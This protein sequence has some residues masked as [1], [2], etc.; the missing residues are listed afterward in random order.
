MSHAPLKILVVDDDPQGLEVSRKILEAE[1][2][3]V[4]AAADGLEALERVRQPGATWDA[5]LTDVRMPRMDGLEF[6]KAVALVSPSTPVVLMTAFGRLDEAV[7][8]MKLGA[9][10]FLAKPFKRKQLLDAVEAATRRA[11]RQ[12]SEGGSSRL[13]RMEHLLR[14]VDQVA[15]TSATLLVQ[16]ESGVGKERLA[17]EIHQRSSRKM[18][19]FIAINCAAIP[20][21]LLESELFGH[22]KGAFT[23]AQNAKPGLFEAASGGTL[24]L[25]EI[26]DM[27]YPLQAK[28][29]RVLQEGEVRR[30]GAIQN[31]KVDVRVIASTHQNLRQRVEQGL[32]R[33]DLFYRLEV[34]SLHVPPL[35]ERREDILAL[36]HSFLEEARIRH[37]KAGVIRFEPAAL[38]ALARHDWPGNIRELSNAIE[39]AVVLCESASIG[40]EDLPATVTVGKEL[41]GQDTGVISTEGSQMIT[42]P[43]GTSLKEVEELL[44]RRT[45]EST[46]GDKELAAQLLGIAARTIYRKLERRE[47][48]DA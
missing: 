45:L 8:A 48:A 35:R 26:G 10:D 42:V 20:E 41:Q 23:G 33:Q 37:S 18:G 22:E 29:L 28:L 43:L 11:R 25:D 5:I 40:C 32:F 9:V 7:W 4:E 3:A 14:Q 46:Q 31:R 12:P 38:E 1:G 16:G 17:R 36:A 27:P 15:S 30:L 47:D 21:A 13:P 6:F 2:Y 34:I 44:I 24:L 39:R 19:P